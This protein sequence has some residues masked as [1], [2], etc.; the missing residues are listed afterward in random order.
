MFPE[1]GDRYRQS[2]LATDIKQAKLGVLLL[3]LPIV[4][5]I[6][7][8]Y[9]FFALTMEFYVLTAL[10]LGFIALEN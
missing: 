4:V 8:D 9:L 7:N 10:R 6:F 1:I 3:I 2:C 5:F